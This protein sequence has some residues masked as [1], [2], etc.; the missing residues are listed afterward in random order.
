MAKRRST[1]IYSLTFK[2]V[3][4]GMVSEEKYQQA[5]KNGATHM[6]HDRHFI[7]RRVRVN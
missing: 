2:L 4:S 6:T 3:K 1:I 7:E 5:I